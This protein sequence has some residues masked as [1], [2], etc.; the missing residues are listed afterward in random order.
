MRKSLCIVG[1]LLVLAVLACSA[2]EPTTIPVVCTPPLCV[3]GG[4]YYCPGECPG[5]CGIQCGAPLA[6][7]E[8]TATPSPTAPVDTLVIQCTPPP[9]TENEV[10]YC[11]AECSGGCGTQCATPTAAAQSGPPVVLSFTADRK[12][13]LEGDSVTLSWQATGGT[14]ALIQWV[15]REA[16]WSQAPGP[17][18]PDGGTVTVTPTGDGDITLIVENG[19][20]SVQA[21]LQLVI[22][23]PYPW[24]PALEEPPPL[25]SGC[26]QEI[27]S[28]VVAQQSFENGFMI[29]VEVEQMVYAFYDPQGSSSHATYESFIDNFAEGDPEMDYTIVPPPGLSQPIR[30]FGLIWRSESFV[31]DRLGWATGPEAGFE[32][33]MQGYSGTGMHNYYTLL[34]GIDGTIYHLT[35]TGSVWEV[36]VP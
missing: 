33:W 14:G 5:G 16:V 21:H 23:C 35:A 25:A 36:Y 11:E 15:S 26:P 3:E 20:G 4:E 17:L 30:G 2:P 31:R 8:P 22:E 1:L 13:I 29:W 10:Y 19:A 27:E 7:G 6:S 28:S 12:N 9:C 24:A 34:R 32:T 18:N